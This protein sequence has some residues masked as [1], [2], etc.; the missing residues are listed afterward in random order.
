MA[1]TQELNS[2]ITTRRALAT[3]A[4]GKP[5]SIS[6]LAWELRGKLW[7]YQRSKSPTLKRII[8]QTAEKL[9]AGN[10]SR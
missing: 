3:F 6:D 8:E 9:R 1:E 10:P 5:R 4:Q 2:N 7:L